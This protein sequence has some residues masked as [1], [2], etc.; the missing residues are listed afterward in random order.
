[1]KS[2]VKWF[3]V[4]SISAITLL[5]MGC[6]IPSVRNSR[7]APGNDSLRSGDIV[8]QDSSPHSAQAGQIKALTRS[9]WSHCG[10]YFEQAA[11][12]AVIIDG[13]GTRGAVPWPE[14]RQ[15]GEGGRFAAYRLRNE[16]SEPQVRSLR[17]AADRYDRRPYDLKFAWDD[18]AIY[19]SELIWKAYRD[20]LGMEVGRVQR[21]GEFDLTSPLARPLIVREG[22]WG[23]VE[24]AE[25]HGNERVVSPQAI[26]ESTLLRPVR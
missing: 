24:N 16:L 19:C 10:I 7:P 25:A 26:I 22:S 6:Q 23:T 21:L 20:A 17:T 1:M 5:L 3:Q 8:F 15:S 14:W 18:E 4:S 12:G 9:R 13:N 2:P 11:G